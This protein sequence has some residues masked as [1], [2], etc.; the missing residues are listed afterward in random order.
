MIGARGRVTPGVHNSAYFEHLPG[1]ADGHRVAGVRDLVADS[2][3]V[4][5][6]TIHGLPRVDV[7]YRRIDDDFLDALPFRPDSILGIPGL[8]GAYRAGNVALANAVR[9]R[10]HRR[11]SDL[12]YVPTFI[13]YYLGGS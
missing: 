1:P 5:M 3:I 8:M 2:D 4:Y 6:K 10:R 13:C 7:I 11:Q 9:K 12:A